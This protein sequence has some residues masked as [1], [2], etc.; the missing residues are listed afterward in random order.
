MGFKRKECSANR[1][2]I[3]F[4]AIVEEIKPCSD[5][6]GI[7]TDLGIDTYVYALSGK[8]HPQIYWQSLQLL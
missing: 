1:S 8:T 4:S 3:V 6:C 7:F 5:S 2:N